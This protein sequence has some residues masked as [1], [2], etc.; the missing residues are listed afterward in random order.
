MPLTLKD[1][2]DLKLD[3]M[4]E[5]LRCHGTVHLKAWGTSMLP[6]V[7]PGD[8]LTI[9]STGYDDL[10]PGDIVLLVR[11]DRIF[12]HRLVEKSESQNSLWCVTRG[13]A[14][15]QHDPPAGASELLG[16][17]VGIHRGNRSFAP[18]RRVSLVHSVLAR[19]FCHSDRVRN[20]ALSFRP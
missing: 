11:D 19:M 6:S 2:E 20:L 7:W 3:L 13:D 5:T 1:H 9:Q 16:R 17:V 15:P 18:S 8:Q 4:I 10:V 12:V 14:M